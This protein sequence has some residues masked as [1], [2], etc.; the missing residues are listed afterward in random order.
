MTDYV[1]EHYFSRPN[2]LTIDGEPY[3][4]IFE[5][6]AFVDGLGGLDGAELALERFR[7]KTIAA[8]FSGLHLNTMVQSTNNLPGGALLPDPDQA[9]AQLRF[10]SV[11][12]YNWHQ[13]YLPT[14]EEFPCINYNDAATYN[15]GLW[16][17]FTERF[18][19]PYYPGVTMGWDPSPRTDQQV[20]YAPGN[21]PWTAIYEGNTPEAFKEALLQIKNF[22]DRSET[23]RKLFTINAWNEWTE[24]SYLLPDTIHGTAYLKAVKEVFGAS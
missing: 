17:E 20:D 8:G 2:Y 10:S 18:S 11:T 12:S 16:E 4:S 19:M 3:F 21:Y 14:K 9:T 15:Y 6:A 5:L 1:I 7:A 13:L 24:G 23:R 22:L